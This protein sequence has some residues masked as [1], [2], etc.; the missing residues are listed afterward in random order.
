M[1]ARFTTKEPELELMDK[2]LPGEIL[3]ITRAPRLLGPEEAEVVLAVLVTVIVNPHIIRLE[4]VAPVFYGMETGFIMAA[5]EAV[6]FVMV[7]EVRL[8][9]GFPVVAEL[10]GEEVAAGVTDADI[11]EPMAVAVVPEEV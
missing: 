7:T 4:M 5:A 6:V 10:A 11:T 2:G 8:I 1:V 9:L 3:I